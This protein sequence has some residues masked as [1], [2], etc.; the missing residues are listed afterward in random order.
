M[1]E[2]RD[3]RLFTGDAEPTLWTSCVPG[4]RPE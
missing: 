2:S 4:W 3:G 1:A